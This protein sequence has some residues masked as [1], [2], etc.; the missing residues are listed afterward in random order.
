MKK[1]LFTTLPLILIT[2]VVG[3]VHAGG[4]AVIR[5]SGADVYKE[6]LEGFRQT[7]RHRVVAEYD[8]RGDLER[9]RE[10]LA[11]LRSTVNPNLLFTVG[12]PALQAA[13]GKKTSLPV[14]YSM[15]FNPTSIIGA[16]TKNVTG[17][18]MNVSVKEIVQLFKELSLKIRRV[19]VVFNPAKS[20]YLVI[21]AASLAR[22][23][24]IQLVTRQIRSANMA[25]QAVNSL[26]GKI[27]ALWIVPD[28]TILG[29]EVL[30]YML[31]FSY[32]NR[33][34][35]LGLSERQTQMGALLSLSYKSSKDMGR[36][37]G[38][39]ANRILRESKPSRIP[40]ITPRQVKLNVNLKAAR[41]LKVEIPNS[42]LAKVDNAVKAPIYEEGD[43]WVFRVKEEG[44][45]PWNARVTY[46]GGEFESDDPD[47]LTREVVPDGPSSLAFASVYLNDPHKK[48]LEFPL[49]P[50]KKWSF[51][52]PYDWS[53]SGYSY[54]RFA[55]AE[56]EVLGLVAQPMKTPAGTFNVI[57]IQRND[58]KKRPADLTYYYSP[59][60][61]S[62]VK[63][64]AVTRG[65]GWRERHYEMELIKYGHKEPVVQAPVY[66][67]GDWWVFRVKI[68]EKPPQEYRITYKDGE[69]QGD[70]PLILTDNPPL[71]SV[72]SNH[73]DIK[74]FNFPLVPGKKWSFRYSSDDYGFLWSKVGVP[75]RFPS[76]EVEVLGP[77]AEPVETPAGKFEIVKIRRITFSDIN[78]YWDID[79]DIELVYF[80]SPHTKSVV[81]LIAKLSKF[82][83]APGIPD[84]IEMELIEYG[85]EAT[86]SEQP[87]VK[88]PTN[89]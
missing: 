11:K 81:K 80:Y 82:I 63:F 36:Q 65:K 87:V 86:I 67:E 6:S 10:A 66:E 34:P 88:A 64:T 51:R 27:D 73:P 49:V 70:D 57:K 43:W 14:V 72:Y 58:L 47:F 28:E 17:V 77:L 44:K 7:I 4:V 1:F 30:Q 20:G 22:K 52:Y 59:E 15:V 69:F 61:K 46:K 25:I 60:T 12:T 38:E 79:P 33:V 26:R 50:G 9:G 37:A 85:G 78:K 68:D 48:W 24:G 39:M 55:I 5:S 76:A 56:A 16:N 23:Q 3:P 54:S 19:G 62:V 41:K 83:S 75:E 31:L 84:H 74:N 32:E 35:V 42:L 2:A 40:P 45:R 21:Q 53:P 8:M 29:D 71:A 13:S 18:S 89:K